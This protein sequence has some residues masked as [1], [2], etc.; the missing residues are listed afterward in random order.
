MTENHAYGTACF[1]FGRRHFI[2]T[3]CV[4]T[5]VLC[6][7][8]ATTA[9]YHSD[10]FQDLMNGEEQQ[11]LPDCKGDQCYQILSCHGLK[12]TTQ[13]IREPLACL[14]GLVF[15][16]LGFV[17]AWNGK[18][19]NLRMLT[20]YCYYLASAL[21][22]I[23]VFD[24][25]FTEVCGFYPTDVVTEA[26]YR[27][28]SAMSFLSPLSIAELKQLEHLK[29]FHVKDVA[30]ITNGF[31]VLWWYVALGGAWILLL[32]YVSYEASWLAELIERGPL[33]IGTHY[34]L[35]QWDEVLNHDAIR[36]LGL[37]GVKSQFVDDCNPRRTEALVLKERGF[38]MG[39]TYGAASGM[40]MDFFPTP[41]KNFKA[42]EEQ[43]AE[44]AT[45]Y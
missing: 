29:Y 17:G 34:G 3:F 8:K 15:F 40:V 1:C 31:P 4:V 36:V 20:L 27:S 13:R 12:G 43:D 28:F 24:L 30:A 18:E 10:T 41:T 39:S 22:A 5:S 37:Q 11:D 6:L 14:T 42:Y 9:A 35:D 45:L 2:A 44:A 23:L 33:G 21:A 16:P 7:L 19:W 38:R 26:I 25:I 32:F